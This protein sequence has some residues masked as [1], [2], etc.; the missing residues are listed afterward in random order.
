VGGRAHG[1]GRERPPRDNSAAPT[2]T[3]TEQGGGGGIVGCG[4]GNGGESGDDGG[5]SLPDHAATA[6]RS[7]FYTAAYMY[8]GELAGT[9]VL[10]LVQ[11]APYPRVDD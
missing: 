2:S 7:F 9:A 6:A 3:A 11:R 4:D 8:E 10:K 1:R 5:E